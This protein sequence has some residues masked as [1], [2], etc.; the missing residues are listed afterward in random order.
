MSRRTILAV[1]LAGTLNMTGTM[2]FPALLPQFADLWGLTNTQAGWVNGAFYVGYSCVV[3]FLVA[4][5]DKVD[6]RTVFMWSAALAFLSYLGFSFADGFWTASIARAMAGV[7]VAGTYMPG[8]K[9]LSDRIPPES[10]SRAVSYYT[11]SFSLGTALSVFLT[12]KLYHL[13]GWQVTS[14]LLAFGPPL[15]VL[16][17]MKATSPVKPV[18]HGVSQ[19]KI[20]DLRPVVSNRAAMG[21][22]LGYAVH[23]FELFAFRGW[24]IA[25]LVFCAGLAGLGDRATLFGLAPSDIA[26]GIFLAG[27]PASIFGNELTIRFGRRRTLMVLMLVSAILAV[28]FGLSSS[29]PY[30]LVALIACIYGMA[31]MW[32]SSALTAGALASA[33]EGEQ[34]ATLGV[35]SLIGFVMAGAA[36]PVIGFVLDV[37]GGGALGW[38]LAFAVAA[39]IVSTGPIWIAMANGRKASAAP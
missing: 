9:A 29:L 8:L 10:Q 6:A 31:V 15:T 26:A 18:G 4:L 11:T 1:S 22:T 32:D 7:A 2:C 39:A 17:T 14:A 33:R 35:Y 19:R 21:F 34:G 30:G 5:T 27:I 3:P 36:P 24:L 38:S 23:C 37:S 20:L 13:V 12:G 25:Y 28:L 16:L